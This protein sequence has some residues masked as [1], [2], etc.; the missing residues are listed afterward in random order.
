MGEPAIPPPSDRRETHDLATRIVESVRNDEPMPHELRG[1]NSPGGRLVYLYDVENLLFR[2]SHELEL[3]RRERDE[4]CE[5]ASS[6]LYSGG[7]LRDDEVD[8]LNRFAELR[9]VGPSAQKETSNG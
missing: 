6:K 8:T 4:A 2:L 9:S 1:Q 5:I 3:T 7:R